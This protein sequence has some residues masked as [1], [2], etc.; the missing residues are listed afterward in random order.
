MRWAR[1]EPVTGTAQIDRELPTAIALSTSVALA[2]AANGSTVAY[3]ETASANPTAGSYSYTLLTPATPFS[4]SGNE[5]VVSGSLGPVGTTYTIDVQSTDG[6]AELDPADLHDHGREQRSGLA[7][8]EP[9]SGQRRH[10]Q[11]L[12]Q[13]EHCPGPGERR[14]QR[15]H[16]GRDAFDRPGQRRL[17]RFG[18]QLQPGFRDGRHE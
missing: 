2:G 3:L 11:Q 1:S 7:G 18:G 9:C 8:G 12:D 4:I 15:G 17:Y 6:L 5:L 14:G 10:G 16:D 13:R